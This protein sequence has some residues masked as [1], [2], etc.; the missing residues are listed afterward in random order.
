LVSLFRTD[1]AKVPN[2]PL[3]ADP[4]EF[5]FDF[6]TSGASVAVA[7]ASQAQ[8]ALF[9]SGDGRSVPNVNNLVFWPFMSDV[10]VVPKVLPEDL[11]F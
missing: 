1:F 5:A 3:N 6:Y 10:F 2:M 8:M 4:H 9:L 7:R 11:N